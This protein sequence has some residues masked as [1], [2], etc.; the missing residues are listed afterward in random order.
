[1]P[2]DPK[3]FDIN[4]L[5]KE[6]PQLSQ[7]LEA[8]GPLLGMLMLP[9]LFNFLLDKISTKPERKKRRRIRAAKKRSRYSVKRW[10]SAR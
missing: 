10:K 4:Q 8:A 5:V 3:Q 7:A 6:T 9:K 2:L 1:M